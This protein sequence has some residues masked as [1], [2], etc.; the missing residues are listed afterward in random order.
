MLSLEWHSLDK[1]R[2]EKRELGN[3]VEKNLCPVMAT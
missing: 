1:E 3:D 2:E